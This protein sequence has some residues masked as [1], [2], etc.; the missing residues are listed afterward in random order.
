VTP[1]EVE[2]V[3]LR[4]DEVLVDRDH[5]VQR[6]FKEAHARKIAQEY[7]PA[8]FGLGHVSMRSDGRYYVMDAQHRCAAAIMA[9]R[10]DERVPFQVWRGLTIAEEAEKFRALNA[11]KLKVDAMSLFK[12]GVQAGVPMCVEIAAILKR[13]GLTYGYNQAEGTV[14]AVATLIQIYEGRVRVA[15]AKKSKKERKRRADLPQSYVLTRTLTVLTDAWGRDRNA[16]D[17]LLMKSVAAFIY[18]HDTDFEQKRLSNLLAKNEA[19]TRVVGK[20][21]TLKDAAR[22]QS[23]A[24]GVQ[25]LEG[26]YNR[27]LAEAKKL[28]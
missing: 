4:P 14:A 1:G 7:S 26:V 25:F 24:A 6:D 5:W 16:F 15:V 20:I 21:R 19:P 22:I 10:G 27:K 12:T 3:L 23:V 11:H 2:I 17:G 28:S 18:K 8:L 9:A 13:F